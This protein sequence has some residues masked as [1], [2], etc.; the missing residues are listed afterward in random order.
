MIR[1]FL[2]LRKGEQRG[3]LL[4]LIL[5][6]LLL[7]FRLSVESP[8]T[9]A[10]PA[11]ND[12]LEHYISELL[13]TMDKEKQRSEKVTTDT[14]RLRFFDPNTVSGMALDSMGIPE[15]IVRNLLS[16]R[17][18]G[19]VI[20]EP[21]GLRKIYGMSEELWL[22]LQPHILIRN[23]ESTEAL[24]GK[25][26]KIR[27]PGARGDSSCHTSAA[28][29]SGSQRTLYI[30]SATEKMLDSIHGMPTF[31]AERIIRY[32]ALIGGYHSSEQLLE[33]Y[34]MDSSLADIVKDRIRIDT[35]GIRK[36]PVNSIGADILARH[37]YIDRRMAGDIIH[38][39][40]YAGRIGSLSELVDAGVVD[41]RTMARIAPYLTCDTTGQISPETID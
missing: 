14:L 17:R 32:R 40:D 41:V 27:T 20:R 21:S 5:L 19:G 34:G 24:P 9:D 39:R 25:Y 11:A 37:P 35:A 22:K 6:I 31:L 10:G 16:Y 18:A 4:A 7:F 12:S 36:I 1:E 8:E 13:R 2:L 30:N 33:V 23:D 28:R 38:F 26:V 3:M 29:P 15:R